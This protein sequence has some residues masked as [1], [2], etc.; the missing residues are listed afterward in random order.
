MSTEDEAPTKK[1]AAGSLHFKWLL[2]KS[3]ARRGRRAPAKEPLQQASQVVILERWLS[4]KLFHQDRA[5]ASASQ[6]FISMASQ[7]A[8]PAGTKSH[9][10][11]D[12]IAS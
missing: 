5:N 2:N 7:Q 1:T 4:N 10:E 8:L 12:A 11:E 9:G 6:V 3:Y